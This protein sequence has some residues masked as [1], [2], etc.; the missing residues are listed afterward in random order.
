MSRNVTLSTR[1]FLRVTSSTGDTQTDGN[2]PFF[3]TY[4]VQIHL[5][6][7]MKKPKQ[8]RPAVTLASGGAAR[9]M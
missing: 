5:F 3:G 1:D 7:Y 4:V 6:T 9:V 2:P 8:G